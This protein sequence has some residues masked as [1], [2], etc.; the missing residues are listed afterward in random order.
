MRDV[1]THVADLVYAIKRRQV[2]KTVRL[3]MGIVAALL[4]T[5]TSSIVFK[6]GG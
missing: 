1:W 6:K 3:G 5:F 2:M 4:M